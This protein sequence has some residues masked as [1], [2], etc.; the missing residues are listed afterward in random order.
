[1]SDGTVF[2]LQNASNGQ[3]LTSQFTIATQTVNFT[4]NQPQTSFQASPNPIL[5]PAG[6]QFGTT[7][8]YWSAPASAVTVEVHVGAPD[9]PVLVQGTNVGNAET[10]QWVTDGMVFY[11]QD[12]TKNK[13]L[14]PAN[15]L[16]TLTVH[17]KQ[18]AQ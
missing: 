5:V 4:P 3:P 2:Y 12:V 16:G 10:G 18:T 7:T 15:T 14:V 13:P 1:V 17:V 11:L 8:L 9:G 6:T